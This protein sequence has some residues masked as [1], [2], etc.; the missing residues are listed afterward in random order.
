MASHEE[1][2]FPPSFYVNRPHF[3][4]AVMEAIQEIIIE[5]EALQDNIDEQASSHIHAG[6]VV[7]TYSRSKTVES[8]LLA[9][10]K[11]RKFSVIV[12]E[13]APHFGGHAMA[14]S[15]AAE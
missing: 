4:A 8:F 6:E 5:L 7:L 1:N 14:K 9:A 11:K 2:Q 15:L 13:G 12:C 3:R 10:A